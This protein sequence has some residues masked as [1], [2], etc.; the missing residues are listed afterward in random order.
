MVS[1]ETLRNSGGGTGR[2]DSW[3]RAEQVALFLDFENLVLGA[4][5]SLPGRVEPVPA[6]ALTWLCRAYG[7]ASIRRAYADWADARF[8]RYQHALERNG[9]DQLQIGRGPSR[10]NAAD[11][12]MAVDAMET[13]ITHPAIGAFVLVT[14]DSDFSPLVSRLRE[15]GKHV[16]GV[17][18]ETAVS[19]RL[20][21]V[22]SEYKLWRS[23]VARV[24]SD[25]AP[26]AQPDFRLADAE[27]LLV[28]AMEQ[29]ST[30]TPTA[31]QVKAK[32]LA[33]DSS[34]D[35]ANYGCRSFRDFLA[36]LG[37]RVRTAGRSGGDITLALTDQPT[38]D[39]TEPGL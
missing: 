27:R 9:V 37:H 4:A 31:S 1:T 6:E 22:C 16:I 18:A 14:G 28:T 35:E 10:K 3:P 29:A 24:E 20:V 34:F 5:S 30:A 32:M 26:A 15:F 7:N 19:A 36:H 8:G 11:I 39:V 2:D 13:L 33:L 21:S 12:R 23:I 38:S 25:A 17:G